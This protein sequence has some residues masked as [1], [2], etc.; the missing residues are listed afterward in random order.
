MATPAQ[1]GEFPPSIRLKYLGL[2]VGLV[3]RVPTSETEKVREDARETLHLSSV[4]NFNSSST[5]TGSGCNLVRNCHINN[6]SIGQRYLPQP[7]GF[8]VAS[9]HVV[10]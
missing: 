8:G 2:G 5:R 6:R 10:R 3:G 7:L 9:P 1:P 4:I